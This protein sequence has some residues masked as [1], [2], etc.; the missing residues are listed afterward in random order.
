MTS[1]FP[2]SI[3]WVMIWWNVVTLTTDMTNCTRGHI[4]TLVCYPDPAMRSLF[5]VSIAFFCFPLS[6]VDSYKYSLFKIFFG[7]RAFCRQLLVS[8]H[9]FLN[10]SKWGDMSSFYVGRGYEADIL[11]SGNA[12]LSLQVFARMKANR[13]DYP[14]KA[15]MNSLKVLFCV[16]I[17]GNQWL[18]W[19]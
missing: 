3:S 16:E 10:L 7:V 17:K 13:M 9:S 6:V 11:M 2:D 12:R 15:S 1:R 18:P 4:Q 19:R 14:S 8:V 5:C